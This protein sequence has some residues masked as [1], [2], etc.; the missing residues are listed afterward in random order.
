M[1][2]RYIAPSTERI[3]L[4]EP[5]CT[6]TSGSVGST[7][8]SG[9]FNTDETFPINDDPSVNPGGDDPAWYDDPTHWGGD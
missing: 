5:V 9:N 6:L 2:K 1:K 7:D 3:L 4:A 8:S